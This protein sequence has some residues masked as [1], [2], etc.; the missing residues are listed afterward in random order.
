MGGVGF[1]VFQH[2]LPPDHTAAELAAAQNTLLLLMVLFENVHIGNCRSETRSAFAISP[3][4]SP[5]LLAGVVGAFLAHLAAMHLTPLQKLLGTAP[6]DWQFWIT[7]PLL[8]LTI[9]AAMELHK[10]SWWWRHR[11]PMQ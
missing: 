8:A 2:I 10:L 9:A 7:L 4:R 6:V 3:F 5:V 11:Q 1:A